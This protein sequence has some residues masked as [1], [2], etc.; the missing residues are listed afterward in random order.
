MLL[1]LFFIFLSQAQAPE[2][3]RSSH[4]SGASPTYIWKNNLCQTVSGDVVNFYEA[5]TYCPGLQNYGAVLTA[6]ESLNK[7]PVQAAAAAELY[8]SMDSG[9]KNL[10]R[11]GMAGGA[12]NEKKKGDQL[13]QEK[14]AV[15]LHP[16]KSY[17]C[18]KEM[19]VNARILY[20]STTSPVEK[21][22]GP[23]MIYFEKKIPGGFC[24]QYNSTKANMIEGW[25]CY[26][27][28]V[29]NPSKA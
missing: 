20:H 8:G 25:A 2:L 28:A 11:P 7:E 21:R 22:G 23:P 17:V 16:V 24:R 10:N 5:K 27:K 14:Y 29:F 18:Y 6:Y 1:G 19:P 12:F 9:V 13:C 15:V 4:Q 26:T 3:T